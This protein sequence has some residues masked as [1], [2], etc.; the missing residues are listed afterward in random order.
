MIHNPTFLLN[1]Q[2]A[3]IGII[4]VVGM[5]YAWRY[6]VRVEDKVDMLSKLITSRPMQNPQ[7]VHV[8]MEN[9]N[10][11]AFNEQMAEELMN[12]VFGN[13]PIFLNPF[14]VQNPAQ[15]SLDQT[16]NGV[17]IEEVPQEATGTPPFSKMTDADDETRSLTPSTQGLTKTKLKRMTLDMLKDVCKEQGLSCEGTRS[18]LMERIFATMSDTHE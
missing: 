18:E 5:F 7:A 12:E 6:L 16:Q 13:S 8:P 17:F 15:T 4:I 9:P 11:Q 10:T 1:V 14:S 3:F 2:L